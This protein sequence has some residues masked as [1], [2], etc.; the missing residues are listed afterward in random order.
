MP[1]SAPELHLCS[2]PT[3]PGL[4][5]QQA[6]TAAESG[7][8]CPRAS[9]KHDVVSENPKLGCIHGDFLTWPHSISKYRYP[10]PAP[11]ESDSGGLMWA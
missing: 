3:Q 7:K 2:R 4:E 5:A 6:E 11:R 1:D 10:G 9:G 8:G